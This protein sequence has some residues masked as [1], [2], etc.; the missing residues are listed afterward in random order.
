MAFMVMLQRLAPAERA[1]LL[2]HDVFDFEHDEIAAL[3]QKSTPPAASCS[4]ALAPRWPRRAERCLPT[5]AST[6]ACCCRSWRPRGK[7]AHSSWSECWPR[8]RR[9]DHRWGRPGREPAGCA[10]SS[11]PCKG[12]AHRR[13]RS[14]HGHSR[15]SSA[16]RSPEHGT[17]RPARAGVLAGRKPIR[18]PPARR[19][20]RPRSS[21]CSFTRT[22]R[23]CCYL[24]AAAIRGPT[25]ADSRPAAASRRSRLRA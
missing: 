19:G 3:I 9:D 6:G 10:I 25:S 8:T 14:H 2:L 15:C 17:Q 23:D 18:C 11:A 22:W 4:S 5:A 7:E 16:S 1:V 21:A 20:R 13:F 24:G 12:R